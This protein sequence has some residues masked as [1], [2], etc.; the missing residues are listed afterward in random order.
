MKKLNVSTAT[1]NQH[2][3]NNFA[4]THWSDFKN[5]VFWNQN[6]EIFQFTTV[7]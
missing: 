6:N 5:S 4:N 3:N 2:C 1:I 7:Q